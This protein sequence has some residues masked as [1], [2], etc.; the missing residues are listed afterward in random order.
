MSNMFGKYAEDFKTQENRIEEY[1]KQ[2]EENRPKPNPVYV[3]SGPVKVLAINPNQEQLTELIGEVA[4]KFDTSY[5]SKPDQYNDN[6]MSRTLSVWITDKDSQ[7][8]PTLINF[9]L[10]DAPRTSRNDKPQYWNM[11]RGTSTNGA[12]SILS[13]LWSDDLKVGDTEEKESKVGNVYTNNVIAPVRIG[14]ESYYM[15]LKTLLGWP[16]DETFLEAMVEVGLDFDTVFNGNFEAL[17]RLVNDELTKDVTLEDG[18]VEKR[19]VTFIGIF[20][21]RLRDD[22]RVVQSFSTNSNTW[23]SNTGNLDVLTR[24][25]KESIEKQRE[26]R[27]ANDGMDVIRDLYTLDPLVE[28][29][30]EAVKQEVADTNVDEWF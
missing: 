23:F 28:Y 29:S 6:K 7:V 19:P 16:N 30:E 8:A 17:H 3:G 15:F 21:A 25:N 20:T 2:Q 10:V 14:E 11:M 9:K 18:T 24:K 4:E 12:W 1:Q 22:G 26:R 5:N 13:T 27:M